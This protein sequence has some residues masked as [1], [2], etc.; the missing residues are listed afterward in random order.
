[1]IEVLR[2]LPP[3]GT[4]RGLRATVAGAGTF[5]IL[6]EVVHNPVA[7]FFAA[8]G[9]MVLLVYV[10]FGGPKRQRFEQHVG[11]IVVTSFFVVLGTLCSQVLWIAVVSTVIVCF[12]VLM[13]GI[14]SSSLAG[15]SSAMLISFLLPVAFHGPLSSIPDRLLGW[16]IAGAVSLV[17]VAVVLPAPST[18]PL[19]D[20]TAIALENLSA[21]IRAVAATE[22]GSQPVDAATPE[23]SA[24]VVASEQLRKAFFAAPFRPA[25]LS[26]SARRLVTVIEWTLELD[27]LLTG[28]QSHLGI[29]SDEEVQRLMSQ[30]AGV[31][32]E[33]VGALKSVNVSDAGLTSALRDLDLARHQVE[34][35]ALRSL[36][37]HETS[38]DS[39]PDAHDVALLRVLDESFRVDNVANTIDKLGTDVV[40][41]V[42][43]RKRTWWQ[44]SLGLEAKGSDSRVDAARRRLKSHLSLRSIWLHNSARA[45]VAIGLSV[46]VAYAFGVQHAFWV[47]F[48]TLAV[49]RSNALST[50]QTI[51]K[52]LT[53][54]VEGIIIGSVIIG[55]LGTHE[56]VFWIL[57]PF[58]ICFTGFAPSAISF[59]AG[60]A[61][62][63]MTI[64]ILFNIVEPTGWTI[65]VIRIEDVAL[66]CAVS[67]AVGLLLWPRG[68]SAT[69]RQ[70]I[71]D[72]IDT[73]V[74]YLHSAV[75]YGLSRCD[76]ATTAADDPVVAR[77]AAQAAARR[78]DD[79]FREF[80]SEQG[81][82]SVSLGDVGTLIAGVTAVRT[83]ADSIQDLWRVHDVKGSSDR[84]V[85]REALSQGTQSVAEWFAELSSVLVGSQ[86]TLREPND[87]DVSPQELVNTVRQDLSDVEG[88]GTAVAFKIV[89]TDDYL[90]QLHQLQRRMLPVI[91]AITSTRSASSRRTH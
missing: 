40:G 87:F 5:A 9:S 81:S 82:K 77:G 12:C 1:V 11:L 84:Q 23:F 29:T 10:E 41:L 65:G 63:T 67:L 75:T 53:G 25:G 88:S 42:A 51:V 69:L 17:A 83:T 30:C 34:G 54:T 85:V 50:G 72:A 71:A 24:V 8:F 21:Y 62:F 89:W 47:V 78:L 64:L 33:C 16:I 79:A 36:H 6:Y 52:A 68:A 49:L 14:I 57:L 20:V 91:V 27:L 90:R 15:A 66:G 76:A 28:D 80:L 35:T 22:S 26:A 43:S 3:V 4:R 73:S 58:A 56:V 74:H 19:V 60:Q 61:G 70:S 59:A 46:W 31:L 32:A 2:R 39:S 38:G 7:A 18:D 13:S 48:G 45:G 55:L 37:R 44:Q 86:V